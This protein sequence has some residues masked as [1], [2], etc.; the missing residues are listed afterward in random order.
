MKQPT[1]ELKSLCENQESVV[2]S[3][4]ETPASE[5]GR[6]KSPENRGTGKYAGATEGG[7]PLGFNGSHADSKAPTS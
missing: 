2:L 1:S 3:V 7:F 4:A 5:A 6:Y